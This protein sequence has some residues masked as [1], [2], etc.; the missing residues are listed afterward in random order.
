MHT[1]RSCPASHLQ[2]HASPS[3]QGC[4]PW[5]LLPVCAH[6][7]DYLNPGAA[8]CMW[9]CWT[10]WGSHG[11]NSHNCPSLPG[12]HP[13]LLLFLF[14]VQLRFVSSAEGALD[15]TA[16]VIDKDIKEHWS[17][18]IAPWDKTHHQPPHGHRAVDQTFYLHLK[19]KGR[20]LPASLLSLQL[21]DITR[22]W[23]RGTNWCSCVCQCLPEQREFVRVSE[24]YKYQEHS[25]NSSLSM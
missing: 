5:A 17:Q 11:L 22:K 6:I 2:D 24:R 10:S 23:S 16:Y 4:S 9:T 21:R 19:R 15:P 14:Y 12:C 18:N 25:Q 3:P 13:F 20:A 8:P 7:W 1:D